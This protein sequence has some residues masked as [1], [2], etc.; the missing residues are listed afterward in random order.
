MKRIVEQFDRVNLCTYNINFNQ[1]LHKPGLKMTV[2]NSAGPKVSVSELT[3]E[4]IKFVLSDCDL[5]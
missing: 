5:R 4:N 1:L 2:N 3:N